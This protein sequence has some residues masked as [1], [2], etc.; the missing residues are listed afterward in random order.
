MVSDR[1]GHLDGISF[2]ARWTNSGLRNR[3]DKLSD[4]CGV[5]LRGFEQ[6]LP[7]AKLKLFADDILIYF[8]TNLTPSNYF[9]GLICVGIG[10][11]ELGVR[12]R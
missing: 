6:S 9:S 12:C 7:H 10:L 11:K 4:S 5:T 8:Y 1:A 3:T 2:L